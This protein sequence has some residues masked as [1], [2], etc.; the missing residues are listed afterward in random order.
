MNECINCH[1]PA[2]ELHH[3][4]PLSLGGNDIES[5]KVWLCT[6]CHSLIHNRNLSCGQLGA[7]SENFKKAVAEHRVG[8]RRFTV[9][10]QFYELYPKWKNKEIT[11]KYFYETIGM[12]CTSFYKAIKLYE[13]KELDNYL[14][15]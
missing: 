4:V 2:T 5:N 10:E 7:K 3:V 11:A 1:K 8:K 12:K 15:L 6:E 14:N 9:P 13:N